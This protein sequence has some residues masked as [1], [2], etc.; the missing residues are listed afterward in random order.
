M[1]SQ[2]IAFFG[3]KIKE[4][5]AN[6]KGV[7]LEETRGEPWEFNPG[8]V[9]H[10]VPTPQVMAVMNEFF[11]PVMLLRYAGLCFPLEADLPTHIQVPLQTE[12]MCLA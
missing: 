11:L 10:S 5:A 12:S 8:G 2:D 3:D 1:F 7:H 9:K 4:K 6:G